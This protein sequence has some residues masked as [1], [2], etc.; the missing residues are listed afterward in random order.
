M[1]ERLRVLWGERSHREQWMLG[2]MF[3]LLA[4]VILWLGV[5]RPLAAAQRSV[6]DALREA[7]DR[8]AASVDAAWSRLPPW[9]GYDLRS[10]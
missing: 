8:N 1:I 4:A 9:R 10:Q 3:A 6:R 7:T 5:A 2:V